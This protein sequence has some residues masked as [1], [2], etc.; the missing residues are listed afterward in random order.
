MLEG[1]AQIRWQLMAALLASR[2]KNVHRL[3]TVNR[4]R[5]GY[6]PIVGNVA[7]ARTD[8]LGLPPSKEQQAHRT[9]A[10]KHKVPPAIVSHRKYIRHL[11][12]EVKERKHRVEEK[13]AVASERW[14]NFKQQQDERRRWLREG[15]ASGSYTLNM[16][17]GS[18]AERKDTSR[19][20]HKS[21]KAS[22]ITPPI[23]RKTFAGSHTDRGGPRGKKPAWLRG[24]ENNK[25]KSDNVEV[26]S[27]I[28]YNELSE[29][30]DLLS[31]VKDLSFEEFEEEWEL[32]AALKIME[33]VTNTEAEG[34]MQVAKDEETMKVEKVVRP[35]LLHALRVAHNSFPDAPCNSAAD[36][37][38][39]LRKLRAARPSEWRFKA[40]IDDEEDRARLQA[41]SILRSSRSLRSVHSLRSA[42]AVVERSK[43]SDK[44]DDNRA[45]QKK[46]LPETNSQAARDQDSKS[47]EYRA[48]FLN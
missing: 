6:M 34:E 19:T 25:E 35:T 18:D 7:P 48:K 9:L 37:K 31:F 22:K 41:R 44:V 3:G 2:P 11:E 12:K 15:I 20:R 40:D 38:S 36:A 32:A 14:Q 24:E 30:A 10:E 17:S 39:L 42:A 26:S 28:V 16:E 23:Q 29:L 8:A 47:A 43:A 13:Y 27:E 33:E 5:D 21:V 45:S 4:E 1:I 46:V